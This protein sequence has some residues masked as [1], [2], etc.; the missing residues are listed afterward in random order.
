M[1]LFS[2]VYIDEPNVP[3]DPVA[4]QISD[5]RYGQTC[6]I[7][8]IWKNTANNVEARVTH[9][10]LYVNGNFISNETANLSSSA[11]YSKFLITECADSYNVSISATNTCG[12]GQRIIYRTQRQGQQCPTDTNTSTCVATKIPSLPTLPPTTNTQN[13]SENGSEQICGNGEL[14]T[15][16]MIDIRDLHSV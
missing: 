9:Y 13:Q 11:Y 12:T 14:L 2:F 7:P 4:I 10:T 6:F 15:I 5:T 16:T 8:I 1:V 3:E